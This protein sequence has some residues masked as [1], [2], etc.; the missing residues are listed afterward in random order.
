MEDQQGIFFREVTLRVCSSLDIKTAMQRTFPYLA[1]VLPL[2]EMYLDVLDQA[3][4]A[5]RRIASVSA[6][7]IAPK[8]TIYPLPESVW[9][10]LQNQRDPVLV[11]ADRCTLPVALNKLM[12]NYGYSETI[13][14]LRIEE[15]IFGLLVL[16]IKGKGHYTPEQARILAS[17]ADPFAIALANALAHEEI[18]QHKND[19]LDDKHFLSR[20]MTSITTEDIVGGKGGLQH[21][22]AMI[23]Q[24]APLN[25]TA[26]ILGETGV[27]KEVIA[28]AIHQA[29]PRRRG[30]FIKVNCGAIP[31]TLIDSELFGHEKGAFTG[32]TSSNRGRFERAEGGTLFLDEIGEL[33]PQAQ[34]RLLRA[35]QSHEIERVG[36]TRTIKVDVR[37]IAATHRNLEQMVKD[38]TFREDLYYRINVFPIPVPPLRHRKEDIPALVRLFLETKGQELGISTPP[39]LA[40]GALVR[41]GEYDW[42]GNV[43]ELEN[44]VERELIQN[45]KGPLLFNNLSLKPQAPVARE[46]LTSM[47]LALDEAMAKHISAVLQLTHGRILGPGGAAELLRINGSTLRNRLRKLGIPFGHSAE[48]K[49]KP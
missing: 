44:L 28:S 15:K 31:E 13:V 5:I 20:E 47:P 17:V 8:E 16:R 45:P 33:S 32:A 7:G 36:G 21:V 14:P 29:S 1:S 26:L 35:I 42:P 38:K 48:G 39:P 10:W 43:R 3:L 12:Q 27:G 37:V 2:E 23:K 11:G 9:D 49:E 22:V 6:D 30:P 24:M 4:G 25:N 34:V 41:L 19:L 18:L 40:P 46:D